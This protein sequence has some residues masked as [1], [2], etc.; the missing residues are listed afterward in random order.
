MSI[1]NSKADPLYI[2]IDV[3][4]GSVRAALVQK[5]GHLLSTASQDIQTWRSPNDHRIYE[6]ST[7]DIWG[8]ICVVVK[9]C[10]DD[11]AA[12]ASTSQSDISKRVGGIGFDA[13]CSLAVVDGEGRGVSVTASREQEVLG[14]FGERNIILWADHRA[15]E[16]AELINKTG[17][18][19]LDYVGG[20]ISLEMEIP[21]ILWLKKHM[22]PDLF[23]RC[24][25]FDLPDYLTYRA[26]DGDTARSCCSLSCK[27]S[28]VSVAA[29]KARDAAA[30]GHGTDS[31]WDDQFFQTIG[32]GELVERGYGQIGL[33]ANGG[34]KR[35]LTA[36]MPV[37]RGLGARAARELGLV[38]GTPVG[39]ALIDAYAGWLGTVG[40]RTEEDGGHPKLDEA[41]HRL[42][43]V[44][45]TSTCHIVQSRDGMFVK[46][47][48]GPYKDPIFPGWWMN[49]G[50]QSATGQLI[51]HIVKTHPAYSQLVDK[52]QNSG[53]SIYDVLHQS[54][55]S[56]RVERGVGSYTELTKDLH[57][58]PDFHGNRSPIADPRMRGSIIG[59]DLDTS[60]TSLALLYHATLTSIAIQTRSIIDTLN[61][62]GHLIDKIYV[63]GSQAKNSVLMKLLADACRSGGVKGVVIDANDDESNNGKK[64]GIVAGVSAVVLGAAMLGRLAHEIAQTKETEDEHVASRLWNI[65]TEMTP[66]GLFVGPSGDSK[67]E[68]RERKLLEVKYVI[69]LEG[70]EAQKR[71]RSLIDESI[72]N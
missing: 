59:L 41:K 58:Y 40:A 5:D 22:K 69:F 7:T 68:E 3:G 35:I 31:G 52:A 63:S 29:R 19:V 57:V 28:Y 4:T 46:G 43:L 37:G 71:W 18:V 50:G 26:T 10:L 60:L 39:S 53:S 64:S 33:D 47:I 65:M 32:L 13:T 54:L 45:G 72:N 23:G 61:A 30:S 21:K 44:A 9:R 51:E 17:S 14:E 49:E 67:E 2:G 70:L 36:G 1:D 24:Q 66:P 34:E 6:Q 12:V 62:K 16:E 11:A 38:K 55:E 20:K 25:F 8:Q 15:E 42:A 27:C 48:W 56:L